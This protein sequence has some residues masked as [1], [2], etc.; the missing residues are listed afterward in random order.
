[1]IILIIKSLKA[2]T[3]NLSGLIKYLLH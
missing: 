3:K 1:M 2:T